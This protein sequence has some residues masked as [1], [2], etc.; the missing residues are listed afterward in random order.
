VKQRLARVAPSV[1]ASAALAAASGLPLAPSLAAALMLLAALLRPRVPLDAVTQR[2]A[3]VVIVILTIAGIRATGMSL[4]GPRLGAFGYGVALTPLLVAAGRS[5]MDRAEGGA[6]GDA[7]LALISLLATGAA[8]PGAWYAAAAVLFVASLVGV[9]RALDPLRTPL[10]AISARTRRIGAA[11]VASSLVASVLSALLAQLAYAQVRKRFQ[12]AFESAYD[13]A[14]G[15]GDATRLGSIAPLLRSDAVVLRIT[16]PEVDRLRGVVLD[17]YG[18][19]GWTKAKVVD[20][21]PLDVPVTRPVGADVV[22]VRHVDPDRGYV[23]LPLEARDVAAP[24][25]RLLVDVNGAARVSSATQPVTVSYRVWFRSG[26]RDGMRV[27]E[28]QTADLLM[29]HNLRAPLTALA[30]EWTTEAKTAAQRVTAI[31]THLLQGFRYSLDPVPPSRL[32]AVLDFLTASRRGDC[33]YFASAFVLLARSLG[34]PARLVLGYRVGERNP[35][36]RHYVVRRKN[37]HAWAEAYLPDQGW[38]TVDPTPMTELPQDLEHD[39]LGLRA[40]FE[41]LAV[42][43]ERVEAWLADLT[44]FE[45]GGAAILG[46]AIFALE[47]WRRNR[48]PGAGVRGDL[49]FDPPPRAFALLAARLGE[50]GSGRRPAE[51]IEQWAARLDDPRVRA[52]LLRYA[53]ARY[54]SPDPRAAEEALAEKDAREG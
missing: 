45:L 19:G 11:I 34:I 26:P 50:R 1:I 16:G 38:I 5:W 15:L 47:R 33:E 9:Q 3:A 27:N 6:R 42:G 8:R 20:P 17:E 23:F 49:E 31:R 18:G 41:V 25:G 40:A 22:E 14:M 37:A 44:V 35:Y 54:G 12:H 7:A 36:L 39:E 51:T 2:L 28:P 46:I 32:D 10:A 30:T 13:E 43:W 53:E 21:T 29:P 52:T 24:I 48:R 4:Q